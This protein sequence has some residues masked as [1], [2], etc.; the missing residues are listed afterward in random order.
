MSFLTFVSRSPF[1][2]VKSALLLSIVSSLFRYN[3]F[4]YTLFLLFGSSSCQITFKHF[5]LCL[6]FYLIGVDC[7]RMWCRIIYFTLFTSFV[8]KSLSRQKVASIWLAVWV[9]SMGRNRK[10][11]TD[12]TVNLQCG[13]LQGCSSKDTRRFC[14]RIAYWA[15]PVYE[16]FPVSGM[17]L[18]GSN[19]WAPS[20]K[21]TPKDRF[22]T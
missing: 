2:S 8:S 6:W 1:I 16:G 3:P 18:F 21:S 9:C 19:W 11:A 15:S 17:R 20:R 12:S 13:R 4:S 7:Y 5:I 22:C 10:F 14:R